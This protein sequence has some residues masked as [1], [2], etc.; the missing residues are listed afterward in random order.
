MA[1]KKTSAWYEITCWAKAVLTEA[2]DIIWTTLLY[3][4]L[5]AG[6]S[7]VIYT[8]FLWV[9]SELKKSIGI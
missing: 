4:T 7:W 1:E 8:T 3:G 9:F 5:L 6:I 2:K